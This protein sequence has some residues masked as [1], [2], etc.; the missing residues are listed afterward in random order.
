[1]GEA[2]PPPIKSIYEP[3][4]QVPLFLKKNKANARVHIVQIVKKLRKYTF[5][6]YI[7]QPLHFNIG[8]KYLNLR[9]IHRNTQNPIHRM[10]N[11]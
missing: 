7:F 2:V 9:Y 6:S 10:Y 11:S 5:I 1:M 8:N 3:V 4:R